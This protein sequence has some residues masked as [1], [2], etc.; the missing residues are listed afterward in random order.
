MFT[1]DTARN[2]RKF[3]DERPELEPAIRT[4]LAA[5]EPFTFDNVDLDS[6]TYGEIVTSSVATKTDSGACWVTDRDAVRRG[7]TGDLESA[8][9]TDREFSLPAV[10]QRLTAALGGALLLVVA[11]RLISWPSVLRD[12]VIV[13]SGND[14]YFYRYWVEQLL[15]NP[16]T[17]LGT[18]PSGVTK[19]EPLLVVTLWTV[20]LLVDGSTGDG[21]WV[22]AWYPVVLAAITAL[23]LDLMA[24]EESGDRRVALAAV[25]LFAVVPGHPMRTS[26]GFTDHHAYDYFWLALTVLSLVV[27]AR[28]AL[29]SR[30]TVTRHCWIRC[31]CVRSDA[32]MGR[33]PAPP[34]RTSRPRYR[35]IRSRNGSARGVPSQT[36]RPGNRRC[37]RL[38]RHCLGRPHSP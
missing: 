19:G 29:R 27:I 33:Q 22:L 24:V 17:S 21:G 2:V 26:L 13:L 3:V 18:L 1:R 8:S 36:C 30:E 10:D 23:L 35:G 32:R 11:L 37:R 31:R 16:E 25:Y 12:G 20:A 28:T 38:C 4:V 14:P 9:E 15:V 7:L 5:E 6:G 34:P